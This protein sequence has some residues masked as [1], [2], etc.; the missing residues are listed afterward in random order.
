MSNSETPNWGV[1]EARECAKAAAIIALRFYPPTAKCYSAGT[2]YPVLR[3][4]DCLRPADYDSRQVMRIVC[5][6]RHIIIFGA[7]ILSCLKSARR[8]DIRRRCDTF[9]AGIISYNVCGQ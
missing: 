9:V 1:A 2:I 5:G 7:W 3:P 4:A 6:G 8:H